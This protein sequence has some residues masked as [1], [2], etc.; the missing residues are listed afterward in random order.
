[1][2]T[3]TSTFTKILT[4]AKRAKRNILKIY[5]FSSDGMILYFLLVVL[6]FLLLLTKK[7]YTRSW[8]FVFSEI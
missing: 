1:M 3:C 6:Y 4:L 7:F 8:K 2:Y 5:A